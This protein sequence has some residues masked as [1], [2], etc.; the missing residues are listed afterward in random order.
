MQSFLLQDWVTVGADTDRA[1]QDVTQAASGWLDL[2]FA[3]DVTF[4]LEV[5]RG[6]TAGNLFMNYE[7]SPLR[8]A[9]GF[10]ALKELQITDASSVAEVTRVALY[11]DAAPPVSRWGRWRLSQ[12]LGTGVWGLAFRITGMAYAR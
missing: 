6:S 7:T 10:R 11:D 12:D 1:I 8:D 4:F 9:R 5:S 3:S 2:G